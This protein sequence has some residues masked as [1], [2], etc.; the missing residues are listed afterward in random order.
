MRKDK[1]KNSYKM[2]NKEESQNI[3]NKEIQNNLELMI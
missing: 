1:E 3:I 2:I